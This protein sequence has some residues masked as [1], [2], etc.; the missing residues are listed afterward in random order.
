MRRPKVPAALRD[1]NFGRYLAASSVS[2]LGSGMSTVALAFAVLESGGVTELGVVL[3]AREIPL[4]V[5]VLLGGVFADRLRR[6]T[7][8]VTTDLIKGA[9]QGLT[10]V[11]FFTGTA[12]VA[13]VSILQIIFG[14]A[15]AFSSPAT[16]GLVREVVNDDHLQ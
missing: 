16:T 13:S 15:S 3:L 6:R 4:V 10:A 7:V 8:L 12:D 1:G 11:L 14:I 9:A 5:F 2:T